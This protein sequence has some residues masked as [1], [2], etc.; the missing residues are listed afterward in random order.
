MKGIA[1]LP[2]SQSVDQQL[3]ADVANGQLEALGALFERYQADVRR[4]LG[5]LGVASSDV[6]DLLQATFLEVLRVAARFDP[7]YA[8][9]NWLFGIATIMLRRQRRLVRRTAARVAAWAESLRSQPLQV[10]TPL[11]L[12]EADAAMRR[13]AQ[14][15]TALSPKKREVFVLLKMEG[16]SGEE[17]ATVLGIPVKTV[18]TRLH[19]ARLELRAALREDGR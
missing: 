2:T 8:L 7:K 16:L 5:R 4:Y 19:H 11:E 12:H 10:R 6:D 13:F 1:R 15:L 9:R 18:W 17:A 3:I 14:A